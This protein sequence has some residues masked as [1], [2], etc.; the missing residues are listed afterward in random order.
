MGR[1]QRAKTVRPSNTVRPTSTEVT[2]WKSTNS[3]SPSHTSE[4]AGSD[5]E[6]QRFRQ[7]RFHSERVRPAGFRDE[8]T[9]ALRTGPPHRPDPL[10]LRPPWQVERDGY[11]RCCADRPSAVVR[12]KRSRCERLLGRTGTASLTEATALARARQNGLPRPSPE[13]LD[14]FVQRHPGR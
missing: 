2:S 6:G 10:R 1:V 3:G 9:R 13:D 14:H 7:G 11:R 12:D 4:D 8:V 5:T